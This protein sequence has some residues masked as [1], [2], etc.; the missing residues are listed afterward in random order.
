MKGES[1]NEK[2]FQFERIWFEHPS[3]KILSRVHKCR[4]LDRSVFD[5]FKTVTGV[6]MILSVWSEKNMIYTDSRVKLPLVR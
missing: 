6:F 5:R 3:N 2:Y 4:Y 1:E